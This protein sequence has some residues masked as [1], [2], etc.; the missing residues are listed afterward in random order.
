MVPGW[1]DLSV[2]TVRHCAY[3]PPAPNLPSVTKLRKLNG[4]HFILNDP[5]GE[6]IIH[7]ADGTTVRSGPCEF[8]YV[9]DGAEYW[10]ERITPGGIWI[11]RFELQEDIGEKPF[12]TPVRDYNAMLRLFKEAARVH[13]GLKDDTM[14]AQVIVKRCIYSIV[15]Q[16]MKEHDQRYMPSKKAQLLEPALKTIQLR[17]A[18][19]NTLSCQKLASLCGIS[20]TYFHRLFT[21]RYGM[22]PKE[23]IIRLRIDRAKQLLP[24]TSLT[25]R[26]IANLCGYA[27]PCHFTR[28]FTKRV[29]MTPTA[30]REMSLAE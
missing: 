19:N 15:L 20:Q 30:Y 25:V 28:E 2:Y 1:I 22:S 16:L 24:D 6:R 26:Q 21:E 14:Y 9:P 13:D 29:G 17:F 18:E 8:R 3:T 23:Y 11:I 10:I 12:S 7:F 4:C 5:V 27:E